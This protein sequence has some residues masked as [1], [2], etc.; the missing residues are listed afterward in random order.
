MSPTEQAIAEQAPRRALG[1]TG[2][3]LLDLLSYIY[4]ENDR[5]EKAAVLLTALD[6]LRLANT[7]LRVSLALA[8]LRSGKPDTALATLERV[9]L[10]GGMNAAFHLVRAQ[11]LVVLERHA[12]A[13]A[14]MRAYI[15]MRATAPVPV[16]TTP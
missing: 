7:R 10:Q 13:A 4:Q 11:T 2:G 14:A 3:V 8:Q 15:A 16:E 6:E 5:P 12:E 1:A 9:A